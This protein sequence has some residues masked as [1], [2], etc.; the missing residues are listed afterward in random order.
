M[1]IRTTQITLVK[2][3]QPIFSEEGFTISIEDE[4]GGEFVTVS[5]HMEGFGKV[6]I[7]PEEWPA[8]REAIDQ[9]VSACRD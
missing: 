3:G 5:C 6:A 7:N 1:K 4:A 2:D 8:L 9:M